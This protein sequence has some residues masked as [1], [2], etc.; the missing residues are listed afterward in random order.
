MQTACSRDVDEIA[1]DV[2]ESRSFF[3]VFVSKQVLRTS[4]IGSSRSICIKVFTFHLGPG[5]IA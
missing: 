1:K 3:L 5:W 2:S 4:D